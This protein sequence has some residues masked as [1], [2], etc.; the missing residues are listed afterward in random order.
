MF[1]PL[2]PG[3]ADAPD[4]IDRLVRFAVDCRC[5]EIFAEPVNPRGAGLKNCQ[6]ALEQHGFHSEAQA[7][8]R[9]RQRDQWSA[10]VT[11]LIADLQRSVRQFSD[12]RKL[13][14]LLYP[15]GLLPQHVLQIKKDDAG[16]VWLG[17]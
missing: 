11:R 10:Y 15:S 5:E 12:I 3:I 4:Q 8:G 6:E 16:V 13:R 2:L 14:F 1:C 17:K 9:I 7:V